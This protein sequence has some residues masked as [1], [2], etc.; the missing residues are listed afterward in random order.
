MQA[1]SRI[2]IQLPS[3]VQTLENLLKSQIGPVSKDYNLQNV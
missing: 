2:E 3:Q 1:Y